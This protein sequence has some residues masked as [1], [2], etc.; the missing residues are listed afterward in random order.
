MCSDG[1]RPPVTYL[2]YTMMSKMPV[3]EVFNRSI[4]VKIQYVIY[5]QE[6]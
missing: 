6:L 1:A 3:S 2:K 4:F 5:S